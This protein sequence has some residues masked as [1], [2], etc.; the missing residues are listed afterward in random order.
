MIKYL[1]KAFSKQTFRIF[2]S[3]FL[4][5]SGVVCMYL[6]L[7]PQYLEKQISSNMNFDII[8]SSDLEVVGYSVLIRPNVQPF[9][10][11]VLE[12]DA[13]IKNNGASM[14]ELLEINSQ[15]TR[16]DGTIAVRLDRPKETQYRDTYY[17]ALP[18]EIGMV[19]PPGETRP[20]R[21]WGGVLM[22]E[23]GVGQQ[24]FQR[25]GTPT[26][27]LLS[28]WLWDTVG[29]PSLQWSSLKTTLITRYSEPSV[30]IF[31]ELFDKYGYKGIPQPND[32]LGGRIL[33][34]SDGS[35]IATGI[36]RPKLQFTVT[37]YDENGKF[38]WW[39]RS[40]AFEKDPYQII[41]DGYINI[42]DNLP[43]NTRVKKFKVYLELVP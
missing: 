23:N 25:E 38:I 27:S 8:G 33:T 30:A 16:W 26:L 17:D 40:G 35:Q 42:G 20:I 10:P 41:E 18:T 4:I 36:F 32:L 28:R 24:L 19:I 14:L 31:D 6:F 39:D 7:L 5:L 11:F 9:M 29:F 13:E 15:V 43:C 3:I 1:Q 21:V 2:V 37:F 22:N 34:L 12:I